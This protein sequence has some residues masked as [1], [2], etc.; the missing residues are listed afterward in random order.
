MQVGQFLVF[1]FKLKFKCI[2]LIK[3][4]KSLL[5]VGSSGISDFFVS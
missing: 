4:M 1:L 3:M 5:K 2:S